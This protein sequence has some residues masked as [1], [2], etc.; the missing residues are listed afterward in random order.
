MR[1]NLKLC[2]AVA[3]ATFVVVLSFVMP[4]TANA[5]TTNLV[6]GQS[7]NLATLIDNS[8]SVEIGDKIFGDF[9]FAYF[10]LGA[11][12]VALAASNV[13]VKALTGSVGFGLEFQQPLIAVN[14]KKKM[15]TFDYTAMVDTNFA[16]LISGVTLAITGAKGGAGTG[17][18]N[19]NAYSDI[20][21]GT[22]VQNLQ[23]ALGGVL[24]TTNSIAPPL[25]KLWIAKDVTVDAHNGGPSSFASI[26]IIDQRFIQ[27]PEPSTIFLAGL[28]LLGVVAVKR[29]HNKS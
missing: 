20:W 6:A 23:A 1:A 14:D 9:S 27:I 22:L 16:N 15:I 2:S 18:V 10:E 25:N 21:G 5:F 12:D 11:A 8:W 3:V 4:T 17:N 28:G 24:S 19:E 7:I 26:S 29:K 13:N